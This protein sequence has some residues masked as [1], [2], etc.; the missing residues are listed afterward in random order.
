MILKFGKKEKNFL[1]PVLLTLYE[2]IDSG[3]KFWLQNQNIKLFIPSGCSLTEQQKNFIKLNKDQ[4]FGYLKN[5]EVYSKNYNFLIFKSEVNKV[6]LSFSQERLWFT[7][8]YMH[9]ST[10]YNIPLAFKLVDDIKIEILE[11]SIK[12]IINRHEILRTLIKQDDE[13]NGYQ[14]VVGDWESKF[15]IDK[16]NIVLSELEVELAKPLGYVYNLSEEYPIKVSIY[17][18]SNNDVQKNPKYYLSVI[19]H[20]IAFDG[21]SIDIFLKELQVYYDYYLSKAK[22]IERA[23][24]LPRL[25]IQ[26]KDFALWQRY[27]LTEGRITMQM[28]YWKNKL[29]D[30]QTLHLITDKPRLK[31]IDYKGATIRFEIEEVT[32]GVLRA[33]AKELKVSLYSLLLSGY[34]LMLRAYSN[35]SDIVIGTPISNRHYGQVDNLIGVFINSLVIRLKIESNDLITQ[36]ISNTSKVIIEAHDNQDLPFEKLIEGLN[37]DRDITRHPIFQVLFGLQS[38]GSSSHIKTNHSLTNNSIKLLQKY[39]EKGISDDISQFDFSTFIDDS[40]SCLKGKFNYVVNLYNEDTIRRFIATYIYILKQFSYL[41]GNKKKQMFTKIA[42]LKYLTSE[43]YK[44]IV[45]TDIGEKVTIFHK[46]IH[47]LFEEQVEKTPD[48]IAVTCKNIT[49]TYRELNEKSNQLA[50]MLKCTYNIQRNELVGLCFNRSENIIVAILAVLKAGGA[51]VP[52]APNHPDPRIQYI[53]GNTNTRLIL[54]NKIYASKLKYLIRKDKA[55]PVNILTIDNKKIQQKLKFE[56]KIIGSA[57]IIGSDLIYVMYTSGTTGK[58]KGVMIEHRSFVNIIHSIKDLYFSAQTISTYSLTDYVFDIFG[59]E[60]G[61]PLVSGGMISIGDY[62]F[63]ILD[64]AAYDFI[65]MTPSLCRLNLNCLVNTHGIKLFVGGEDLT[66]DL[67]QKIL[68]KSITVV[69]FYGPTETTIWSTSKLYSPA[70]DID[71]SYVSLGKPF[72]N[73]R[74]YVL[75]RDMNHVPIGAIGELYIGGIGLARKYLNLSELTAEKFIN[76]PFAENVEK[77]IYKTGDL[78]R[79]LLGGEIQYIER[80]DFQV[81]IRGHRVELGEI[82]AALYSYKEIK[83]NVVVAKGYINK[84]GMSTE[85][86]YL[87]GYYVSESEGINEKSILTYL[88]TKLPEYM[89]PSKL[90]RLEKF[91]LTDSGKLNRELLPNPEFVINNHYVTPKN[92]VEHVLCKILSEVLDLAKENISTD[93]DFFSLGGNSIIAIKLITK[94]NEYY[95]A[96]LKLSDLFVHKTVGSLATLI[97]QSKCNYQDIVKLNNTYH[98]TNM[99]MI[100]SGTGGCEVYAS[101]AEALSDNFSCYGVDSYNLYHRNKIKNLHE[102]SKRYLIHIDAIMTKTGQSTYHLLGWSLGGEI[103]L[104][105]A[106]ILG[107]RGNHKIK[108]YILDSIIADDDLLEQMDAQ[109][110]KKQ[111]KDYRNYAISRGYTASYI[112]RVIANMEIVHEMRKSRISTKISNTEVLLFKAMLS[113][114]MLQS[115]AHEEYRVHS[116]THTYNNI[117]RILGENSTI[118]LV[119]VNN[120]HHFNILDYEDLAG[121]IIAWRSINESK[122]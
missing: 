38:F 2:F 74:I 8:Q 4:I 93:E 10:S 50:N 65:Q 49:L 80:N 41:L 92:E 48:N 45:N 35:Q 15:S 56:S 120:M 62:E 90:V 118:K 101:L 5:S 11:T 40:Q 96:K 69:N 75:D 23:L 97:S 33:L 31:T 20:H 71:L 94:I 70:E 47:E 98:K 39:K 109:Y 1:C 61:L 114:D 110:L 87:I 55:N 112:E 102:I 84:E 32:S 30:Y 17:E 115:N 58:P 44:K 117:N 103:A 78:V 46:P 67:L 100:H 81:K 104:E 14:L 59:L 77:R 63:S 43:E 88:R 37:I 119:K 52:I 89:V 3:I 26:Y 29:I 83:E 107:Q 28:H 24:D 60:Y 105:I 6:P 18:V 42:D 99:F 108:T 79:W 19:I 122:G 13:G 106:H 91:P 73:E 85:N 7:E 53:I 68:S 86:K 16:K 12:S 72:N 82:E 22:G 36:F 66:L 57:K 121:E 21:W 116:S 54:T 27:Y 34:Y 111:Q 76:N 9:G 113:Y 95:R 51:Y 25:S 64:C